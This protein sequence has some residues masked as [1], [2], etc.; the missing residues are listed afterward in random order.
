[1]KK[2]R[3]RVIEQ[4]FP[5]AST[6]GPQ[7]LVPSVPDDQKRLFI[8]LDFAK[9]QNIEDD[10]RHQ[11]QDI[12]QQT[13]KHRDTIKEEKEQQ[14]LISKLLVD[15]ELPLNE[16]E[17]N[18]LAGDT[19]IE[20]EKLDRE[21]KKSKHDAA[22]S[23]SETRVSEI[24][25]SSQIQKGKEEKRT[26]SEIM[27]EQV[28]TEKFPKPLSTINESSQ[29]VDQSTS[30]STESFPQITEDLSASLIDL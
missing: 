15:K 2:D 27:K 28:T 1:V 7:L 9:E 21:T 12:E 19:S 18:V 24:R 11:R 14:P 8:E 4:F 22:R 23:S 5:D 26:E 20:A 17:E 6:L 25:E 30:P 3:L 16:K 29:I 10:D 13:K